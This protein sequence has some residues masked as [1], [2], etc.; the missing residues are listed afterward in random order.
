MLRWFPT[1]NSDSIIT[2]GQGTHQHADVIC[3]FEPSFADLDNVGKV[4][5]NGAQ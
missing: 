4:F 3:L 5:S 2:F 1:L